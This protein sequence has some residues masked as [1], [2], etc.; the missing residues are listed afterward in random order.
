MK[1]N[2]K[3]VKLCTGCGATLQTDDPEKAGFIIDF[4]KHRLC[5]RCFDIKNYNIVVDKLAVSQK[6]VAKAHTAIPLTGQNIFLVIDIL[7]FDVKIFDFLSRLAKTNTLY[8]VVNKI[9][10]LPKSLKFS[11]IK[12]YVKNILELNDIFVY[13]TIYVSSLKRYNIDEITEEIRTSKNVDNHFVGYSNS[14]KSTLINAIISSVTGTKTDDIT[15]STIPGTTITPLSFKIYEK[16]MLDYP[17]MYLEGSFQNILLDKDINS[18]SIKQEIYPVNYALQQGRCL[19]IDRAA[20]L[21][22]KNAEQAKTNVQFYGSKR[23]KLHKTSVKNI[24]KQI[25]SDRFLISDN[26]EYEKFD[27]HIPKNG[28][29][30]DVVLPDLGRIRMIG[31]GQNIEIMAIK[32]T[33]PLVKESLIPKRKN[34][35]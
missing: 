2:K 28:K 34:K 16:N 5:K 30:H 14:G 9:D 27:F 25:V 4:E 17:G 18:M 24:D 6:E 19:F 22:I 13:K 3:E 32:G 1:D 29:T 20:V 35:L 33:T 26:Y 23:L 8:V 11:R 10:V 12:D 21:T 7:S 31:D 15:T